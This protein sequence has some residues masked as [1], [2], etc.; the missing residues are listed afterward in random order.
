[1][2]VSSQAVTTAEEAEQAR[3]RRSRP[4]MKEQDSAKQQR[5]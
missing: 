3:E 1:M 4:R 5:D 2:T